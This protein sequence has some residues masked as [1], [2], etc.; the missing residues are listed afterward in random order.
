[1]D[2]IKA[3]EGQCALL[4]DEKRRIEDEARHRS[5]SDLSSIARLRAEND[6]LRRLRVDREHEIA[7]INEQ[8]ARM[9]AVNDQ[10]ASEIHALSSTNGVRADENAGLK[11]KIA[12]VDDR[13]RAE[14]ATGSQIAAELNATQND[15]ELTNRRIIEAQDRLRV[16]D[17]D[18][19][20][21]RALE[22]DLDR[23]NEAKRAEIDR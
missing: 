16:T 15:L 5:D 11:A 23:Q 21:S 17:S 6:D 4:N 8:I 10:K 19:T 3:I 7:S 22:G 2:E 14:R 12:D 20:R 18:L 1:M 9:K 13:I